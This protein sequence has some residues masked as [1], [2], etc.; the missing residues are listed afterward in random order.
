[1]SWQENGVVVRIVVLLVGTGMALFASR[2]RRKKCCQHIDSE[3][4]ILR[5]GTS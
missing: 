5:A 4:W 2:N 1:V 3:Q